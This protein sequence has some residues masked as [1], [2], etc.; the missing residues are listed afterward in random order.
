MDLH[1]HTCLSPC[2][3]NE[4]VPTRIISEA[5]KSLD[6]IGISDHNSADNVEAVKEAGRR[7]GFPVLGGMEITTREEIHILAF[8]PDDKKLLDMQNIIYRNLAGENDEAYFGEQL[9]VDS[10]DRVIAKNEKLLIGAT[11]LSLDEILR[12]IHRFKGLAIASHID[13]AAFSI[14]SQLGFI[15]LDSE[16][17]ALE[18]SPKWKKNRGQLPKYEKNSENRFEYE[19]CGFPLV[20]FSDAHFLKNIGSSY[21][22]FVMAEAAFGELKKAVKNSD[23]RGIKL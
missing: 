11:G 14:L 12:H 16:L 22:T 6:A 3:D 9:V 2:A 18:L 15:P 7:E 20:T 8:F 10:C 17:D 21:T 4:M 23:S 19:D 13:K 5:R 1:I